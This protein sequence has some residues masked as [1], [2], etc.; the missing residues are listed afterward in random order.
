MTT[1][2]GRRGANQH[3]KLPNDHTLVTWTAAA[4]E[5]G[6]SRQRVY[7][8]LR[9]GRLQRHVSRRGVTRD[10]LQNHLAARASKTERFEYLGVLARRI[11]DRCAATCEKLTVYERDELAFQVMQELQRL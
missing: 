6:V 4:T 9:E 11:A 2:P 7:K 8:L 5:I 3:S 10:S 1:L